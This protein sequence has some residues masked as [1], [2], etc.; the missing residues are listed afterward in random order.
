MW[1]LAQARPAADRPE[2]VEITAGDK[3][4]YA[5]RRRTQTSPRPLR[6]REKF[7]GVAAL[8][9][10]SASAHERIRQHISRNNVRHDCP[11]RR[12]PGGSPAVFLPILPSGASW[13]LPIVGRGRSR[14]K[15]LSAG[16]NF[17]Q[18]R[19]QVLLTRP[20]DW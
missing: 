5:F 17:G 19:P 15:S 10:Q 6:G 4:S 7:S 3:P 2:T 16:P 1:K 14:E 12:T 9:W 20:A 11:E 13:T 8:R 18:V